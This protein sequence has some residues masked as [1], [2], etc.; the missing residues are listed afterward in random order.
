[1]ERLRSDVRYDAVRILRAL[2]RGHG[3]ATPLYAKWRNRLNRRPSVI[4][5]WSSIRLRLPAR[6]LKDRE[7]YRKAHRGHWDGRTT[8]RPC[9]LN[10]FW[11]TVRATDPD[12]QLILAMDEGQRYDFGVIP[13][14]AG[15]KILT[16]QVV[17]DLMHGV[18]QPDHVTDHYNEEKARLYA[19][20]IAAQEKLRK[21]RA[22]V[23]PLPAEVRGQL[24]EEA[25]Q[26]SSRLWEIDQIYDDRVLRK[27]KLVDQVLYSVAQLRA[28]GE[29][30]TE[31]SFQV[32]D[33]HGPRRDQIERVLKD[34]EA[35]IGLYST[36]DV[37]AQ[38]HQA[39]RLIRQV[40]VC[41][42]EGSIDP[43]E[44][45]ARLLAAAKLTEEASLLLTQK[46]VQLP[47]SVA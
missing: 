16:Y 23:I 3:Q 17:R 43:T 28:F 8:I 5:L 34:F 39:S 36:L 37:R 46:P 41:L 26:A 13:T 31:Y 45:K 10:A 27:A 40:R 1:M 7:E 35:Q 20:L 44:A 2:A 25:L 18:R 24:I 9:V 4:I 6:S 30:L 47:L 12:Y 14:R 29:S 32:E 11:R 42:K 15:M 33:P 19:S 38:T 22:G 21:S